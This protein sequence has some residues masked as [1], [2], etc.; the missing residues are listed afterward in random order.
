V[1]VNDGEIVLRPLSQS[2]SLPLVVSLVGRHDG[3]SLEGSDTAG[4]SMAGD[5]DG[6][7]LQHV[8]AASREATKRI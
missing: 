2:V 6:L 3:N 7:L 5:A 4:S 1:A 8:L